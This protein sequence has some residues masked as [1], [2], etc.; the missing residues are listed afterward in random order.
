MLINKNIDI[1]IVLFN[2]IN[3]LDRF[4]ISLE[5]QD[6]PLGKIRLLIRNNLIDSKDVQ[7]INAYLCINKHLYADVVFEQGPKM[8]GL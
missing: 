8:L 6:F 5:K 1:S 7:W 3:W 2:S 4:F